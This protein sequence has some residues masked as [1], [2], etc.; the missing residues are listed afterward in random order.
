MN[1]SQIADNYAVAP[2]IA[3]DDVAVLAEQGFVAIICNRPDDED[4]GQPTAAEISAAC[5]AAGLAFHHIPV[6]GMPVASE[7][8]QEQHRLIAD[9][10]GPVLGYCRSGQRSQFIWAASA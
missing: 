7:V 2:Q 5:D 4:S 9:S 10:G 8:I 3:P 1:F 6:S